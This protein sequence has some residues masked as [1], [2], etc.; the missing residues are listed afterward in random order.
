MAIE[1]E[2]GA[3]QGAIV[4]RINAESQ[5]EPGRLAIYGEYLATAPRNRPWLVNPPH[6][7]GVGRGLLLAAVTH[8]YQLGLE[9]RIWLTS[10]P[11]ERTRDFYVNL[12][13]EVIFQKP[14]GTIDFELP[15]ARALE[16]LKDE[17]YLS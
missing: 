6:L 11:S 12:G 16:W 9:G 5:L 2:N 14:D 13:F 3:I 15:S 17:G 4:Y 1:T 7:R 8:S 10:L